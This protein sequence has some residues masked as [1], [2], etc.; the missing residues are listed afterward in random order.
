MQSP[1]RIKLAHS[2]TDSTDVKHIQD[3]PPE[4]FQHCLDFVGKG[5]FA[6]VA[7]VS[8][9][10]YWEYINLGVDR[11]VYDA[12]TVLEQGRNKRTTA[13]VVSNGSL[14]LAT[15]CFL[16]APKEFKEEVCRRAAVKGRVDILDCGV[17]LGVDMKSI[18]DMDYFNDEGREAIVQTLE[19]GHLEVIEFLSKEDVDFNC[20]SFFHHVTEK[21]HAR[22]LHWMMAKGIIERERED[23][24][25]DLASN[26]ELDVLKEY[27]SYTDCITQDT[28]WACANGGNLEVMNWM[29]QIR[30]CEWDE[31]LFASAARS[32][33]I[34]MLELCVQN[35]CHHSLY[36]SLH[37]V[38]TDKLKA[39]NS[40]QWLHSY[41][42]PTI[43]DIVDNICNDLTRYGNLEALRWARESGF[44]WDLES[45]ERTVSNGNMN[46]DT[47]QYC[48]E[49][50]CPSGPFL[51]KYTKKWKE[52]EV[53]QIFKWLYQQ[54]VPW[55]EDISLK[56]AELGH[57]ST[58]KWLLDHGC[59]C[60]DIIF[61]KSVRRLDMS[62][63]EIYLA[64][65]E[66]LERDI[67]IDVIQGMDDGMYPDREDATVIQIF[68]LF[69]DYDSDWDEDLIATA[70]NMGR[71]KVARWLKCNGCPS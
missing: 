43:V 33:S 52:D 38:Q 12:D 23:M 41:G 27:Y 45:F 8:K 35:G 1:N 56:E 40:L 44:D 30:D 55:D 70:E 62:M 19:N 51:Y 2:G 29:L 17:A 57:L 63:L 61:Y 24:A 65:V 48:L 28:F 22:D 9:Q 59:I 32:G 54:G 34:P 42:F 39:L 47:L 4:I 71:T 10:F 68:Q 21:G 26:G 53:L 16:K 25:A 49:N 64:N 67:Y 37:A 18:F 36:V 58:L 7:P 11:T 6:F 15:E 5:N 69:R 66:V 31:E 3:L 13:E 20:S 50:G 46:I 60:H 14:R